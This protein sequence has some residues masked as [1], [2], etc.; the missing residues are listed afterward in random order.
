MEAWYLQRAGHG[1]TTTLPHAAR[2]AGRAAAPGVGVDAARLDAERDRGG[3]GR[4]PGG[5]EPVAEAGADGGAGG[6]AAPP[7]PRRAA[8]TG[9]RPAGPG[10][11]AAGAGPRGVRL[12][13]RRVDGAPHRRGPGDALR[14]AVPPGARQPADARAGLEPA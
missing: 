9:A 4:D 13:R 3:L 8:E 14:G 7:R 2:L 12:P 5:G 1:T 10:A 11:G 6:A